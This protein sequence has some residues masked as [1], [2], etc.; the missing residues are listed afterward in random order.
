M[1]IGWLVVRPFD[2]LIT[3]GVFIFLYIVAG[4]QARAVLV[5]M[6][7]KAIAGVVSTATKSGT[8]SYRSTGGQ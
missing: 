6:E 3:V 2:R 4:R 7:A 5:D 1:L 8:W